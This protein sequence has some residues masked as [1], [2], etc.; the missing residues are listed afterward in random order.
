MPSDL[1]RSESLEAALGWAAGEPASGRS[2]LSTWIRYERIW[3]VVADIP[4]GRVATYGD[5]ARMAGLTNGARQA[6]R[7]MRH[8]PPELELPWHRV[9]A[10]GGRIALEGERGREQRRR[11][12]RESVPFAGA[13]VRLDLCRWEA[14]GGP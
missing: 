12:E 13:R 4:A 3:E 14:A 2:R 11:L 7:A 6:G 5:L 10:A 8:C 9:V 1:G